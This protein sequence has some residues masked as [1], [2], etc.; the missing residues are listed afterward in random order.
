MSTEKTTKR[1]SRV[2]LFTPQIPQELRVQVVL[3]AIGNPLV[4]GQW[5]G[6]TTSQSPRRTVY[7]K[8]QRITDAGSASLVEVQIRVLDKVN[9]TAWVPSFGTS[10]RSV[11]P[12]TLFP[13]PESIVLEAIRR[14]EDFDMSADLEKL[15]ERLKRI[16]PNVYVYGVPDMDKVRYILTEN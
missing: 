6:T 1:N 2:K 8:L 7:G 14:T 5:Y 10:R 3:D 13:I 4:L 9:L 15:P 11:H 12:G 16:D